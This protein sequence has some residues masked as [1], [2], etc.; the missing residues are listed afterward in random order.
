VNQIIDGTSYQ[1][2]ID[3][4]GDRAIYVFLESEEGCDRG[5]RVSVELLP[6]AHRFG[7]MGGVAMGRPVLGRWPT[8]VDRFR[9]FRTVTEMEEAGW[10]AVNHYR[11]VD[12]W[13]DYYS[14][15]S[16]A[17]AESVHE[18]GSTANMTVTVY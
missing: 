18:V 3:G 15:W 14:P 17:P 12:D 2:A 7:G 9:Q 10:V 16:G 13:D 5:D 1:L 11:F 8:G 6:P 4:H